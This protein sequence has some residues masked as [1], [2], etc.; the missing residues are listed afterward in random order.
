MAV[1]HRRPPSFGNPSGV[2]AY[3][4]NVYTVPEWR[5]RGVSTMLL[6]ATLEYIRGT[7][8]TNAVLHATEMGRPVYEKL[9]FKPSEGVMTLK[10]RG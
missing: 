5:R 3:I 7:D 10:L 4:M 1:F 8:A 2:D 9:G 6:E